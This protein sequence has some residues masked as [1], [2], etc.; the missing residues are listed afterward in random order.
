VLWRSGQCIR[1]RKTTSWVRRSVNELSIFISIC[2][3]Y[4]LIFDEYA[5]IGEY[6]SQDSLSP[7]QGWPDWAIAYFGQIFGK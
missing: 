2:S 1:L 4:L 7:T 5:S 3:L 6:K